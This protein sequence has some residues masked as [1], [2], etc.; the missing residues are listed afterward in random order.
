MTLCMKR[1][2]RG[3]E[4]ERDAGGGGDQRGRRERVMS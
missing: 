1:T 3:R 2:E 4:R